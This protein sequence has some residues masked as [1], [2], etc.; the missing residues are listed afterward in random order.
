MRENNIYQNTVERVRK[1][2]KFIIETL[3][4]AKKGKMRFLSAI[5]T[6]GKMRWHFP[7]WLMNWG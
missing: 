3:G 1:N 6:A 2:G 7:M 4:K 5:P